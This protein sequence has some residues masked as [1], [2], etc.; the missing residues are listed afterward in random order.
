MTIY[1]DNMSCYMKTTVSFSAQAYVAHIKQTIK[2]IGYITTAENSHESSK[3]NE[4][5]LSVY[6]IKC[7]RLILA[8]PHLIISYDNC[9][10][11]KAF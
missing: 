7:I 10:G 5:N 8:V 9:N 11:I 1:G 3:Q 4:K 6:I 2:Q